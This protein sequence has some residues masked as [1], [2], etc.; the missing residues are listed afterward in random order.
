MATSTF[1]LYSVLFVFCTFFV[2]V[3]CKH[4]FTFSSPQAEGLA[5]VTFFSQC[6]AQWLSLNRHWVNPCGRKEG[7]SEQDRSK[8]EAKGLSG[9]AAQSTL[10]PSDWQHSKNLEGKRPNTDGVLTALTLDLLLVRSILKP[11]RG[12]GLCQPLSHSAYC[13]NLPM[14]RKAYDQLQWLA[15]ATLSVLSHRGIARI[16]WDNAIKV[17]GT[18]LRHNEY[19]KHIGLFLYSDWVILSRHSA[20]TSRKSS[21]KVPS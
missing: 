8:R 15:L 9:T 18:G 17:L 13:A 4:I 6:L 14:V 5:S 1:I 19:P 12:A 2:C 16:K 20:P 10:P 11:S 21:R 7:R 3:I